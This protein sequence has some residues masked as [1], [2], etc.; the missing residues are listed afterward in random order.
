MLLD[1]PRPSRFRS[2]SLALA[3]AST[4]AASSV[5]VGLAV[6]PAPLDEARVGRVAA[7][8]PAGGIEV[9]ANDMVLAAL[10]RRTGT[11]QGRK[12]TRAALDRMPDLAPV[13]REVLAANAL[14]DD[15]LAVVMVESGF[16]IGVRPPTSSQ[17]HSAGPWQFIPTTARK[18][19]L[20]VED[21]RDERLEPRRSTEAAAVMLAELRSRYGEWPL[22]LMAYNQGEKALDRAI[23][24]GGTRDVFELEREGLVPGYASSVYAAM[25]VLRDPSLAR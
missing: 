5:A 23:E 10:A 16:Q 24:R 17:F 20:E 1:P 19:G 7:A 14:P 13:M 3:L 6:G 2:V 12:A 15:L 18:Y 8:T 9:P 21:T 25:L 11:E 4:V 22:A